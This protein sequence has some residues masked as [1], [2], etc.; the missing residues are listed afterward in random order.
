MG[1]VL[2]SGALIH[3]TVVHPVEAP[4]W[5]TTTF[6]ETLESHAGGN[7]ANTSRALGRIGVK[8]RVI[9]W[10]GRDAAGAFLKGELERAAV[11]TR[12]VVTSETPTA[13]T[14]VLVNSAGNRKFLHRLGVS[15]EAFP[16]P[17]DFTADLT[18]GLT[19]YHMASLFILPKL[20]AHA[21]ETL[22]RARLAGLHT[23]LDTNWDPAGQWLRT[24]EPCLSHLHLL[25]MNEDEARMVTATSDPASAAAHVRALGV[26]T[27]VLKLG[28]RGCAIYAGNRE[29]LC[30]AF[31]V[32]VKDTTGAGDC[33][34]AGFLAARLR[35]ADW[36]EAGRFANAVG[37][38]SVQQT[39]ASTGVLSHP[40]IEAWMQGCG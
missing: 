23:S 10:L 15:V 7:G 18:N 27:V 20:Q 26:Q 3:D 30:P 34:V 16:T 24:L 35:G 39:G 28:S 5:G 6:V 32:E 36:F 9:G 37:A 13:A 4:A 29:I 17:V 21:G 19:H 1:G 11:D 33:F 22:R 40:E 25:F 2:V 31:A 38:L 14:I 8:V 12:F